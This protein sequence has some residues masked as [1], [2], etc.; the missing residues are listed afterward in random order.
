MFHTGNLSHNDFLFI[1]IGIIVSVFFLKFVSIITHKEK[2]K[3]NKNVKIAKELVKLAKSLV[4]DNIW[5]DDEEIQ[6]QDEEFNALKD[7]IQQKFFNVLNINYYQPNTS[8]SAGTPSINCSL[9]K[10]KNHYNSFHIF[11]NKEGY[12]IEIDNLPQ[13]EIVKQD[14]IVYASDVNDLLN[15]LDSIVKNIQILKGF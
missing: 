12:K 6:H 14:E 9:K 13:S 10:D 3:M 8:V 15:K 5:L 7:K 4:A 2:M 11:K 1:L